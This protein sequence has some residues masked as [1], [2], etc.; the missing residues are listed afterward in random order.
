MTDAQIIETYERIE[1]ERGGAREADAKAV[2]VETARQLGLA[3]EEVRDVIL[4]DWGM[5]G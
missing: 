1:A 5:Q 3:Y 4:S 2:L